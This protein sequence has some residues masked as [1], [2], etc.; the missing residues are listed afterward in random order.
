MICPSCAA[1]GDLTGDPAPLFEAVHRLATDWHA[2]CRGA[3]WCDCQH[4][5]ASVEVLVERRA[6]SGSRG[7]ARILRSFETAFQ[8]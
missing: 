1:A 4:R 5:V 7:F 2:Q 3:A 8:R 6:A